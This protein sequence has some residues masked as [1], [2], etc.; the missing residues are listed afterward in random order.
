MVRNGLRCEGSSSN[1]N[2]SHS[3]PACRSF[4]VS[5]RSSWTRTGQKATLKANSEEVTGGLG[6]S[7]GWKAIWRPPT[8]MRLDKTSDNPSHFAPDTISTFMIALLGD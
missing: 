8:R 6:P 2:R 1:Q 3:S 7:R 5:V 4:S